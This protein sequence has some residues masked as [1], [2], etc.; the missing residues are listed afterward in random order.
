MS[1]GVKTLKTIY[2]IIIAFLVGALIFQFWS[3]RSQSVVPSFEVL[4]TAEYTSFG[5]PFSEAVR[6]GSTMYVSGSIGV[7]PGRAELVPGGIKEETRQAMQN[8]RDILER[9]GS[10]MDKVAKCTVFLSDMAEWPLM[11]EAY[12]EAFG[13]HRPAR[14]AFGANGL[15]LGGR[16]EIECIAQVD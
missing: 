16:V 4:T 2:P 12:I 9:Y 15:A 5:L 3:A 7:E 10:S 11:N 14:S 6:I 1:L 8:I 13:E